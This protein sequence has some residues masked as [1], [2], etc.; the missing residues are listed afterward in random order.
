MS[1]VGRK[2]ARMRALQNMYTGVSSNERIAVATASFDSHHFISDSR[3]EPFNMYTFVLN[4]PRSNSAEENM[5]PAKKVV[6]FLVQRLVM[7]LL[8]VAELYS[9]ITGSFPRTSSRTRL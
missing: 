9:E 5:D 3:N 4:T 2:Y 8:L 1:Q 7:I 6:L